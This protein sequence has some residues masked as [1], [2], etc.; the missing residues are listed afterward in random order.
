VLRPRGSKQGR[1]RSHRQW[2]GIHDRD[3]LEAVRGDAQRHRPAVVVASPDRERVSGA[4]LLQEAGAVVGGDIAHDEGVAAGVVVFQ[5]ALSDGLI[6]RAKPKEGE[7]LVCPKCS[8]WR[9]SRQG[10]SYRSFPSR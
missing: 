8:N 3:R 2:R 5:L 6:G 10:Q 1:R 7:V 9:Q 4:D